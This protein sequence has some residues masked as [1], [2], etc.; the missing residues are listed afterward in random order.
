MLHKPNSLMTRCASVCPLDTH[1]RWLS[2]F[3]T[4]CP[5]PLHVATNYEDRRISNRCNGFA[6]ARIGAH[7]SYTGCAYHVHNL[8]MRKIARILIS[9]ILRR[10]MLMLVCVTMCFFR[11]VCMNSALLWRQ[12]GWVYEWQI[13][14]RGA[15]HIWACAW[16]YVQV[17]HCIIRLYTSS[18]NIIT[19]ICK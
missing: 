10:L 18:Q 13:V 6:V 19:H 12:Y 7:S 2:R 16:E 15:N 11:K 1:F 14:R 8:L 9:C 3:K 17:E 5:L 4:I